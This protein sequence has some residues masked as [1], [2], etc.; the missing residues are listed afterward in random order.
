M[1]NRTFVAVFLTYLA[2]GWVNEACATETTTRR[3]AL[4][5][6]AN[7]GGP[8]RVPLSYAS[9]DALSVA[10]VFEEL[11]GVQHEDK[12]VL[13]DPDAPQIDVAFNQLQTYVAQA[14]DHSERT[15]VLFYYSGHSDETGLLLKNTKVQYRALR[16][17]LADIDADVR[18]AVLDSCESGAFTHAKGGTHQPPF[19]VDKSTRVKGHVF[20]T[21]SSENEAAQ[22]SDSIGGSF[23]T[24]YLVSA[25]RGAADTTNDRRVTLNEAYQYAYNET[26]ARTESTRAGA[27]HAAYDIQLAGAGDLVL[28]DLQRTSSTLILPA[29]LLGR[30]YIR[31]QVGQLVVELNKT[32]YRPI[33]IGL[34]ANTYT[35]TLDR[36]G[37]LFKTALTMEDGGKTVFDQNTLIQVDGERTTVRGDYMPVSQVD[38][39]R[40]FLWPSKPRA[41][42]FSVGIHQQ[43]LRF[44]SWGRTDDYTG[45]YTGYTFSYF[46]TL[47]YGFAFQARYYHAEA[48]G[49]V[50]GWSANL[51]YTLISTQYNSRQEG[52]IYIG[53]GTFDETMEKYSDPLFSEVLRSHVNSWQVPLGIQ[54]RNNRWIYQVAVTYRENGFWD[55][56]KHGTEVGPVLSFS[57]GYN[58]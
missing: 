14:K 43:R 32:T 25:L 4:I 38:S 12:I 36:D 6:G 49:T 20:L 1:I 8:S 19:L 48:R 55:L 27:Q 30:L 53:F 56:D 34:E 9:T 17:E 11:G 42:V 52:S 47:N 58:F 21:S 31:N 54:L 45:I 18:V 51:L 16:E 37:Q 40:S 41:N 46:R 26:L 57:A 44:E 5:I 2:F 33:E 50:N 3:F 15:E 22:E 35:V 13:L 10:K 7:D 28:T 24:H 23:F 29:G 39:R